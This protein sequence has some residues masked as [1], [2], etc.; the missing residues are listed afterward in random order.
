[1][2]TYLRVKNL[3]KY[4]HYKLRN[5]PWVKLHSLIFESYEFCQLPDA[6]RWHALAI[7]LLAA[8]LNNQ[9]PDDAAW[10]RARTQSKSTPDIALLVSC[11]FVERI[12]SNVLADCKQSATSETEGETE[13]RQRESENTDATL[14]RASDDSPASESNGNG[15]VPEKW[16]C[17]H[18]ELLAST[19]LRSPKLQNWDWWEK[20]Y[21]VHEHNDD[22]DFILEIRKMDEW[23]SRPKNQRRA[24]TIK[25]WTQFVSNW[26]R[27]A[28]E[29]SSA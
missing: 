17:V 6:A 10:I 27:R 14:A 23:L 28:A 5:P 25:D 15:Q 8:K 3:E 11:G 24:R 29:D 2:T 4:Q 19:Y 18:A 1:M 21:R 16:T 13:K 26:I 20:L 22:L 12:A 9:V 7:V